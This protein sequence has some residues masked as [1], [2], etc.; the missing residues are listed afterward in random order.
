MA[1]EVQGSRVSSGGSIPKKKAKKKKRKGK[2]EQD[3][4]SQTEEME[5]FPKVMI[6]LNTYYIWHAESNY[7]LSLLIMRIYSIIYYTLYICVCV[8]VCVHV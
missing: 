4:N 8:C 7:V 6:N 3:S 1:E 2:N 5:S